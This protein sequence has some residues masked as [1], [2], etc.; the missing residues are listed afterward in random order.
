MRPCGMRAV[1]RRW[2]VPEVIVLGADVLPAVGRRGPRRQHR[3]R[4]LL[5]LSGAAQRLA[6]AA[7]RQEACRPLLAR[8]RRLRVHAGCVGLRRLNRT[9]ACCRHTLRDAPHVPR[10]GAAVV[11]VGLRSRLGRRPRRNLV[12]SRLVVGAAPRRPRSG[13]AATGRRGRSVRGHRGS[14]AG[15]G[16]A[17]GAVSALA[18]A[19]GAKVALARVGTAADRVRSAARRGA[20]SGGTT[21]H[22]FGKG[23]WVQARAACVQCVAVVALTSAAHPTARSKRY[24]VRVR[25]EQARVAP[26]RGFAAAS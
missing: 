10:H 20:G 12:V 17:S 22:A 8:A 7:A 6:H 26:L 2:G 3:G 24:A 9:H 5:N 18:T 15:G 19:V 16:A 14:R 1:G 21:R 25:G 4:L 13:S 23:A 11:V